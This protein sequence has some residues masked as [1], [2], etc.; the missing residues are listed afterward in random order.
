VIHIYIYDERH[1]L[2]LC[3]V[4]WLVV[5]LCAA[6]GKGIRGARAPRPL[7]AAPAHRVHHSAH[8][9]GGRGGGGGDGAAA[10]SF[11]AGASWTTAADFVLLVECE[12]CMQSC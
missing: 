7:G 6:N 11:A 9:G 12:E 3:V 5:W 1:C 10:G 2:T 4:V 8:R